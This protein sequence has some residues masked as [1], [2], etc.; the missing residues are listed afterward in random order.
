VYV[1]C[2]GFVGVCWYAGLWVLCV[3]SM[4]RF[5]WGMLVCWA[6]GT[7]VSGRMCVYT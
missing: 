5:C 4:F 1:V 2:S 3:C 7:I 6:V